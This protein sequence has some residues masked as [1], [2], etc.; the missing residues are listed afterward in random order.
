M[1][2]CA[3]PGCTVR[4]SHRGQLCGMCAEQIVDDFDYDHDE[5]QDDEADWECLYP[6][7]CL[8]PGMGHHSSECFT[9]EDAQEMD[10]G[11]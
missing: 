3:N 10:G 2:K 11:V 5:E 7:E 4:V 8:M 6:G 1:F 9:A